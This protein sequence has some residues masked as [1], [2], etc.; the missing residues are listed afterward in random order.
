[1]ATEWGA[2]VLAAGAVGSACAGVWA[3][4]QMAPSAQKIRRRVGH[5]QVKVSL[6]SKERSKQMMDL[7][8]AVGGAL[9]LF[10]L[11]SLLTHAT[12]LAFA[13]SFGGFMI[14]GWLREWQETRKL[15][16]LSDQ[17]NRVMGMI[18]TSLK[19]GTPLEASIAQAA[20]AMAQPMGP[21]L[22][23]LAEATSMGVT[24]SQAV[25]Q[26]RKLPVV[27]ASTDFQVFATEMVICHERGANVIQA[28]EALRQVLAARRKYRDQVRENM[29]QH[30]MQSLVI[31][32]IGM[33]VLMAYAAM[34]E[35]GLGPLLASPWGQIALAVSIL[36]NAFLIRWTHISLLRQTKRV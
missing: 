28:F 1:M 13:V 11:T 23:N 2:T 24:L 36:G 32:G 17:L 8:P 21:V 3:I 29:G 35:E 31:A 27:T 33:L 30:L 4:W 20:G 6:L 5:E 7:V 9:A 18:A 12:F 10:F 26:V 34:T 16:Q 14:P 25:E 19:R 15:M 22:R